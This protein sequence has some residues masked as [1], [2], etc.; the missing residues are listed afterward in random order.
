MALHR[1]GVRGERETP[2]R[3]SMRHM[4]AIAL[5]TFI[6]YSGSFGGEFV[7]DDIRRVRDNLTIRSLEWSH[8]QEIFSTFDGSNYMPLKVLSLA[9]D[10]QLWGPNPAGYH[11]TNLLIHIGSALV[12]YAFLIRLGM[13]PGPACLTALLWAVHPLQVESVAWISERKNVLSGLFFFAA[14]HVYLGFSEHRRTGTYLAVLLLYAMA[15]LSKMNTM[16]LPAICL[17]YEVTFRFRLRAS[18]VVASLPLFGIAVTVAWY[19]LAGNP[20]H[21]DSWHGASVIVT[22]LS[23]SVVFFRYLG[24]LLLPMDLQPWYDVTLRGSLWDPWVALSVVGLLGIA[25]ATIWLVYTRREGGFWVLWFVITLLPMLNVI[26]PFRSLM[27]DR[28]MYV[29][30][31]GPL[32]LGASYLSGLAGSRAARNRIALAVGALA[33]ACTVLSYRQVQ[34]WANPLSLWKASADRSAFITGDLEHKPADYDAQVNYLRSVVAEN[35][36]AV[37]LN[38]LGSLYF[39]A[40]QIAHAFAHFEKAAALDPDN[41]NIILNLGRAHLRLGR[42][43]TAEGLLRRAVT[44]LPYSVIAR[45]N[46]A[47]AYLAI[48]NAE[49]ARRELDECQRLRPDSP[50]MWQQERS[51]LRQLESAQS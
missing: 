18:D 38:N 8:I 43:V 21:G 28:Y 5:A 47:R 14:F 49:G 51:Y 13:T 12:I 35:P 42:A 40:G 27:Q 22:W 15:V 50:W 36:S 19:N 26:I 32:A 1:R 34:V 24:K 6:A 2:S 45:I 33:V 7:S 17:V 46:L 44:L 20:I 10:Y 31:V 48:G 4:A 29:P 23:S 30:M 37:T 39:G 3:P 25:V 41:P 9:I 16:V 11:L